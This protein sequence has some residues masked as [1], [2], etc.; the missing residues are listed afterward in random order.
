MTR[1]ST[2]SGPPIGGWPKLYH[3]DSAGDR[4]LS[5]FLA[6]QAAYEAL[7][8]GPGKLR[9]A[10]GG[11][12]DP[13][14]TVRPRTR[15]R[16]RPAGAGPRATR[17]TT[18]S[19]GPSRRSIRGPPGL[20]RHDRIGDRP[21]RGR[22][23]VHGRRCGPRRASGFLTHAR[24][25]R[26]TT[27][28]D[29]AGARLHVVRRRGIRAVRAGVAGGELVRR[30]VGYVLDDQSTRVRR[31]PQARPGLPGRAGR[32]GAGERS[33]ERGPALPSRRW[34]TGATPAD[35]GRT[36]RRAPAPDDGPASV[37]I[38]GEGD[39]RARWTAASGGRDDA[40]LGPPARSGRSDDS[41]FG[42]I[43]AAL[44]AVALVAVLFAVMAEPTAPGTTSVVPVVAFCG[45]AIVA[46]VRVLRRDGRPRA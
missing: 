4:A 12:S 19:A 9:S 7:T 27:T 28:P 13:G 42:L 11:R 35:G 44:L 1:R 39:G 32:T 17:G 40:A 43:A 20:G 29:A 14:G 22:R 21:R 2:R 5:R 30:L 46:L 24:S 37:R 16:V 34:A 41:A 3:P 10:L 6:V 26:S 31:P 45:I 36:C 38:R 33:S 8:E 23:A 18:G 15:G 25:G